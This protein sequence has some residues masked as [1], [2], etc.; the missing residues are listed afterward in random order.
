MWLMLGSESETVVCDTWKFLGRLPV[1]V[2]KSLNDR[3]SEFRE[4]GNVQF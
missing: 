4:F 1:M 2:L 3:Q